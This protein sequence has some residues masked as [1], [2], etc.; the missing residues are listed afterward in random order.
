MPLVFNSVAPMTGATAGQRLGRHIFPARFIAFCLILCSAS[1]AV[2]EGWVDGRRADPFIFRANYSLAEEEPCYDELK[3]LESELVRT[4]ALQ[5]HGE[6]VELYLFRDKTTYREY[7][8]SYY[9]GV[10]QRR[11]LFVKHRGPGMVY[12]YRNGE[13]D[14]DLR[15][16]TTHALLHA[17]L[18]TVP[19]WLDEG[20]AEYFEVPEA[21]RAAAN[22]HFKALKWNLRLGMIPRLETLENKRS[23][24]DMGRAEYRYSWAWV[25]FMLHGPLEAHEELI[26]YVAGLRTGLQQDVLSVRLKRRMPDVEQRFAQHFRNW[27][28]E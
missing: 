18:P 1:A 6:P 16:E 2:G 7:L 21:D 12:A 23:V 22:P 26:S 14:V 11:A 4:L 13:F 19:L 3:Q 5:M 10:P 15:H 28:R 27:P 9:P 17:A 8:S 24:N 25:H 20:L